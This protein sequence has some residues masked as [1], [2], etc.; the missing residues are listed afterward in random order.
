MGKGPF[1]GREGSGA[2]ALCSWPSGL[3]GPG[4]QSVGL[5][6]VGITCLAVWEQG[7]FPLVQV[8]FCLCLVGVIESGFLQPCPPPPHVAHGPLSPSPPSS[9][10][11]TVGPSEGS[12]H[13]G[14][15]ARVQGETSL[16]PRFPCARPAAAAHSPG[17]HG[18]WAADGAPPR[19][20]ALGPQMLSP[21]PEGK[22]VP[23][24]TPWLLPG[25]P[26]TCLTRPAKFPRRVWL[27]GLLSVF[28]LERAVLLLLFMPLEAG[29]T[30]Q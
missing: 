22:P 20:R 21:S 9:M 25:G 6:S 11:P 18:A 10:P 5:A 12:R 1:S 16:R 27:L 13:P 3:S 2:R 17:T 14:W 29:E 26:R 8:S 4:F 7:G 23:V 24:W 15:A 19:A 30:S 28:H